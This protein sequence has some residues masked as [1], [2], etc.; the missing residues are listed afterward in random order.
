[1]N[2]RLDTR[3]LQD[4]RWYILGV[5]VICLLVV[6]MDN[7]I[8]NVALKTIQDDLGAS[9]GQ[10]E[11]A[12]NSYILVFAALLFSFGVLADRFGRKRMLLA[13][14]LLFGIASAV[15]AFSSSPGRLIATRAIMGIGAAAVFP[16]T[17]SIITNVFEPAERGRAIAIWAGFSGMAVALGPII[18]G[19]LLE[20]FWWGSV[21][22]INVPFVIVG[23]LAIA[24]IVPESKDPAPK[25]VDPIGVVLSML[26]LA[27]LVYGIIE[28]G[29]SGEWS[30]PG[31]LGPMIG[32]VALL[33][34]FVLV[35]RRSSHPA[36][37]V[38]LFRDARFSAATAAVTLMFFG[39]S[40][41]LFYMSFYL[42]AV[43]DYSPLETG[44]LFLPSAVALMIAAPRSAKMAQRYGTKV[45]CGGGMALAAASMGVFAFVDTET[46]IV[47]I[48]IAYFFM[49]FG[50][51]NI[52]APATESIMSVVPR[53]K[54]GAGSAV[55]NTVRQVGGALGVAILGSLT[56]AVYRGDLGD[57]VNVL[58]QQYRDEAR[59]SIGGT[60]EG[61]ARTGASVRDGTLE[62]QAGR[63][64]DGLVDAARDSFNYAM[65]VATIGAVVVMAVGVVIVARYMPGRSRAAAAEPAG[66]DG[67]REA[68]EV[69]G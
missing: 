23:V 47:V 43:R 39:L 62:P 44:L 51:G 45:V 58:P 7:T 30:A 53:E 28:G 26:G 22:L 66:P 32:G 59:E 48:E 13:G 33:V 68:A 67:S 37:D 25:R 36:L 21:F 63:G 65:H 55:N 14:L 1:M 38:T 54:A 4:R 46:P 6:V 24:A 50:M 20:H 10:M 56:S 2:T 64:L 3:S 9:Q 69:V 57:K 49:G 29:E 8:L 31:T 19:V 41:S 34:A 60:L 12:V 16:Q 15:S 18:G 5:L 35:E 42:Q 61:A 52:I 17:L 27:A 40:G 11:W